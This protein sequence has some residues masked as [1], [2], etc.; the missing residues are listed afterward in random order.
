MH[1][2]T[3][4]ERLRP[5]FGSRKGSERGCWNVPDL[6]VGRRADA[7]DEFKSI[8]LGHPEIDDYHVWLRIGE[9]LA[10]HR[11]PRTS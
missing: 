3:M 9:A 7:P 10:A 11:T 1:F 5:I 6:R 4:L 2:E 8:H